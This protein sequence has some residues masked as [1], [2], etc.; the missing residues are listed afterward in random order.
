M[1]WKWLLLEASVDAGILSRAKN[2]IE[3]FSRS[4]PDCLWF[5]YQ[6]PVVLSNIVI[7]FVDW[8]K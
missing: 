6:L 4:S 1:E 3:G 5:I 8:L 7:Q 2:E